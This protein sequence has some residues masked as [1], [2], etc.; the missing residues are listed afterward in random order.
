MEIIK[1]VLK[2]AWDNPRVNGSGKYN[3]LHGNIRCYYALT[4]PVSPANSDIWQKL[5]SGE[6]SISMSWSSATA[7]TFKKWVLRQEPV[8]DIGLVCS[9]THA[10]T[11]KYVYMKEWT[12]I[13]EALPL[14]RSQL[15]QT[16]VLFIFELWGIYS[17]KNQ[18]STLGLDPSP[19]GKGVISQAK[20]ENRLNFPLTHERQNRFLPLTTYLVG[21]LLHI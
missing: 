1:A 3:T 6:G 8:P 14:H 18:T 2:L 12:V 13:H 11:K 20:V 10:L 5:Q 7:S 9:G 19:W 4:R 21:D 15:S 16:Q 17:Q